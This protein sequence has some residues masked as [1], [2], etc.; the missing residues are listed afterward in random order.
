MAELDNDPVANPRSNLMTVFFLFGSLSNGQ[1]I[2]PTSP[3]RLIMPTEI[4][5]PIQAKKQKK[6]F[7]L[8]ILENKF[9]TIIFC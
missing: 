4:K 5:P 6:Y 2:A 9:K 1:N 7:F 8:N 3:D